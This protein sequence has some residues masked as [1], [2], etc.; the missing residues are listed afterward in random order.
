MESQKKYYK[1][2]FIPIGKAKIWLFE[3]KENEIIREVG[4]D[5]E[6]KIIFK[7]PNKEYPRG[8][9]GD[10][11]VSFNISDLIEITK[12]EFEKKWEEK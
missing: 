9:F 2:D 12:D 11:P 8:L 4:I 6:E 10:S 1:A 5:N 3:I 7:L